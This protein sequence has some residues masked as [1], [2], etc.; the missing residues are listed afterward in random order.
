MGT[1]ESTLSAGPGRYAEG[2]AG[3]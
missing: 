3:R 1:A 2:M